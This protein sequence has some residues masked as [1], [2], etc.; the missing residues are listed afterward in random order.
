MAKLKLSSK[1]LVAR[2]V[3]EMNKAIFFSGMKHMVQEMRRMHAIR[4]EELQGNLGPGMDPFQGNCANLW[5]EQ[6]HLSW[7]N[8]GVSTVLQLKCG[9]KLNKSIRC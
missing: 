7:V 3:G 9:L 4:V 5:K 6:K 8:V 1:Y 2:A